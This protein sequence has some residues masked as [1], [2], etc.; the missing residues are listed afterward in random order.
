MIKSH[1]RVSRAAFT[2]VEILIVV[3]VIGVLMGSAVGKFNVLAEKSR[4]KSCITNQQLIENVINGWCTRH[5]PL[6][7]ARGDECA[8]YFTR[9]GYCGNLLGAAPFGNSYS[10]VNEVRDASPF[11]C[12]KV[13]TDFGEVTKNIPNRLFVNKCMFG[14]YLFYYNAPGTA[15]WANGT[16]GFWQDAKGAA[17]SHQVVWCGAYGGFNC[18]AV[19]KD[20]KGHLHS[21]RWALF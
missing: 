16:T 19:V 10:I 5:V 14:N 17:G 1:A 18:E 13:R 8:S 21:N 9:T 12:P 20:L 6:P 15:G 11:V 7:S 3:I 2:M 4:A